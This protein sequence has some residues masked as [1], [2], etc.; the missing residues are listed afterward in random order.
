[1]KINIRNQ[2]LALSFFF[3]VSCSDEKRAEL[4]LAEDYGHGLKCRAYGGVS[5]EV[6]PVSIIWLIANPEKMHGKVVAVQGYLSQIEGSYYL[7]PS[8][9]FARS[10]DIL[11]SIRCRSSCDDLEIM[12]GK[13]TTFIGRFSKNTRAG[14][15]LFEPAG[16]VDVVHIREMPKPLV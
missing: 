5:E 6:C 13:K 14:D 15:F 12:I 11:S 7:F 8:Q 9:E 2:L 1:M 16:V 10:K 4:E 3:V